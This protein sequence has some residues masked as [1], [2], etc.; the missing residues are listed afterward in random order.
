[1]VNQ[2][3][4]DRIERQYNP[5]FDVPLKPVVTWVDATLLE[6]IKDQQAQI[7]KLQRQIDEMNAALEGVYFRNN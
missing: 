3:L 4:I 2:H 1:M 6:I 7:D 5:E